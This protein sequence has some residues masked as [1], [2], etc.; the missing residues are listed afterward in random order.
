MKLLQDQLKQYK[1][2]KK[3]M[4]RKPFDQNYFVSE[5]EKQKQHKDANE[6]I[7]KYLREYKFEQPFIEINF[8][9]LLS[10]ISQ[11]VENKKILE[12]KDFQD[13]LLERAEKSYLF[14]DFR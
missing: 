2:E 8:I 4:I 3:F 12:R 1:E 6:A 9:E 7:Q 10:K 14:K 11:T 5:A 13:L